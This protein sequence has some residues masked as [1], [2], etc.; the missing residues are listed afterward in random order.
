MLP[1]GEIEA[2]FLPKSFSLGRVHTQ[3]ELNGETYWHND[4]Y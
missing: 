2:D 4:L 1:E 3:R